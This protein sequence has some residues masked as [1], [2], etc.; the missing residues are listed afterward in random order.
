MLTPHRFKRQPVDA[1]NIIGEALYVWAYDDSTST[2]S[3]ELVVQPINLDSGHMLSN[4]MLAL[5]ATTTTIKHLPSHCSISFHKLSVKAF[6]SWIFHQT[7][8]ISAMA[9]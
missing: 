5:K 8:V 2:M 9:E 4:C 6:S 3:L 1:V 7:L